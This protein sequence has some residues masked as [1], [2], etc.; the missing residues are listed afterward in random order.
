MKFPEGTEQAA[1]STTEGR[2]SPANTLLLVNRTSIA[3]RSCD[4]RHLFHPLTHVS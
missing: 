4:V 3:N 2:A 1:G